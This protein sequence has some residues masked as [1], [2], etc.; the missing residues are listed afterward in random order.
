MIPCR[1]DIRRNKETDSALCSK[2]DHSHSALRTNDSA[3]EA[4]VCKG[5]GSDRFQMCVSLI[6]KDGKLCYLPEE[7]GKGG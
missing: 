1:I 4:D 6:V 7:P 5:D 2:K 3:E